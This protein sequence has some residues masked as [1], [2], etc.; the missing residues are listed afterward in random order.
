LN[1]DFFFVFTLLRTSQ[2]RRS[3]LW[4][5]QKPAGTL[6]TSLFRVGSLCQAKAFKRPSFPFFPW[7][8]PLDF[9]PASVDVGLFS[10]GPLLP[11]PLLILVSPF[12]FLHRLQR[13]SCRR[14]R[15]PPS[16]RPLI[17]FPD[18]TLFLDATLLPFPGPALVI[19]SVRFLLFGVTHPFYW[20][21]SLCQGCQPFSSEAPLSLTAWVSSCLSNFSF[22][23]DG[24]PI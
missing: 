19:R 20:L 11:H 14:L 22:P 7:G 13:I 2:S 8:P 23:P 24:R 5:L 3:L 12:F 15:L 1:V 21:I 10:E 16:V 4:F 17:S 9:C 18:P 6:A